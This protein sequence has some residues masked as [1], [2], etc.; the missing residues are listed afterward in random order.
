MGRVSFTSAAIR[1]L[2]AASAATSS[3]WLI[4]EM[5]SLFKSFVKLSIDYTVMSKTK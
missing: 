1:G 4:F 2:E 5:M 3:L